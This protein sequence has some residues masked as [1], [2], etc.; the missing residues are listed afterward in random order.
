MICAYVRLKLSL[1]AGPELS[2]RTV[3]LVQRH[4]QNCP[5]CQDEL[6]HGTALSSRLVHL[7]P[8]PPS[9]ILEGFTDGVMRRLTRESPAKPSGI[10]AWRS[11]SYRLAFAGM[12]AVLSCFALIRQAWLDKIF[13]SFDMTPSVVTRDGAILSDAQLYGHT[14]AI[15]V[16]KDQDGIVV[17]WLKAPAPRP[18]QTR[19]G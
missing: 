10:G 14:A 6:D 3:G 16:V 18:D 8:A 1:D 9:D 7:T 12:L 4:L 2:P 5:R 13:T 17:V 11:V 19:R 15:K